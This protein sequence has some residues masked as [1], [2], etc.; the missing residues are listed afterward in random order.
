MVMFNPSGVDKVVGLVS[1]SFTYGYSWCGPLR[2]HIHL[3]FYPPNFCVAPRPPLGLDVGVEA[4]PQSP[5]THPPEQWYHMGVSEG[6]YLSPAVS[7]QKLNDE[8]R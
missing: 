7:I 1:V 6:G 8:G 4:H 5:P 3:T 2:G